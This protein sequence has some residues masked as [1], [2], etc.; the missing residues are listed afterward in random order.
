MNICVIH[1]S[2]LHIRHHEDFVLQKAREIASCAFEQFRESSHCLI[3]VTGDI[4]F[5]GQAEEYKLAEAFLGSIKE[6]LSKESTTPID[7]VIVPGNHD[8]KLMPENSVRSTIIESVLANQEKSYDIDIVNLCTQ[9]Q[10]E[11]FAFEDA[12]SSQTPI[13]SDKL[14]KE[15]EINIGEKKIRLSLINA[16]WMSTIHEKPGNLVYPINNYSETLRQDCDFRFTFV[17]HP[18]NWYC[19]QTYHEFRRSIL[20]S[21]S[22]VFSGHE[23]VNTTISVSSLD[24]NNTIFI[25][26]YAL[27]PHKEEGSGFSVVSIDIA[28]TKVCQ[29]SYN[30][31]DGKYVLEPQKDHSLEI[32][33]IAEDDSLTKEFVKTLQDPGATLVHP[34]KAE[35]DF[36]DIYVSPELESKN[37][38]GDTTLDELSLIEKKTIIFG[39]EQS[40]KTKVL[41]RSF[42]T[43]YG[44]GIY[45]VYL[46]AKTIKRSSREG[47][48]KA[49][50]K[51]VELEYLNPEVI[52]RLEKS[53]RVLLLDNYEEI[54]KQSK[55][56]SSV[57]DYIEDSF[58]TVLITCDNVLNS[59][60]TTSEEHN[61]RTS[62]YT[63]Y[64][65][66]DFGCNLRYQLI[67][68]WHSHADRQTPKELEVACHNSE[69][70]ITT[71]LGKNLVPSRPLFLLVLMQSS[72]SVGSEELHNSG[73]SYYYQYLITKNLDESGV[74]RGMFDE[75]FTYLSHLAWFYRSL[76]REYLEKSEIQKFNDEFSKKYTTV[77]LD[78][79][80]KMLARAKILSFD[81]ICYGFSYPYI[82]YFFMGKFFA[83]N[84][85]DQEIV[86]IIENSCEN[87]S[88]RENSNLILFLTHH[89]NS[90]WVV[91]SVSKNLGQCFAQHPPILFESDSAYLND[92]I[93]SVSEI[94]I[95]DLNVEE[96]Q[97]HK[98]R[99]AEEVEYEPSE[100]ELEK[101]HDDYKEKLADLFKL[102]RSTEVLGQI[103]KN[104][105]GSITRDK[106]HVYLK[107]T[108]EAPLRLLAYILD[109]LLESPDDLIKKIESEIA[110]KNK[111]MSES[112]IKKISAGLVSEMIRGICTGV[113]GKAAESIGSEKLKE[114]IN[115]TVLEE[116][117]NAYKLIQAAVYLI[118]PNK[119]PIEKIRA[120]ARELEGNGIAYTILQGLVLYHI[121]MFHTTASERQ[122]LGTALKI[123]LKPANVPRLS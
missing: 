96:S 51:A 35:I 48:K 27:Q 115:I 103:L 4:A 1:L 82:K 56:I 93:G 81:G 71:V 7:F 85:D 55:G 3:A 80:L 89:K 44:T 83:D 47:I 114:D 43:L 12:L 86:E 54:G 31:I 17:H 75:L 105:Y 84:I 58:G 5:S 22:V 66:K 110:K 109:A 24:S 18:L 23:H 119:L 59:G 121:H 74:G 10:K 32:C 30:L 20:A 50:E 26:S 88:T 102:I 122:Q 19:Q 34:D 112:E 9:A 94:V 120:L 78:K 39:E 117:S 118:A 13:Y 91:D 100:T 77:N 42:M 68:R 107:E 16:S 53:K 25:E 113:V 97:E 116:G 41:H 15:M 92:L 52:K 76:G 62:E 33:T 79:Q 73:M 69:S 6:T 104:Y 72:S 123:N 106:K 65:I 111:E 67:K 38:S 90:N 14:W 2:D 70:V 21:S 40:G 29:R 36:S 8:C 61:T 46:D 101:G 60:L 98:R 11:F 99:V 64:S 87:L 49:I 37:G 45:P 28:E 95:S 63:K 108:I 57:F